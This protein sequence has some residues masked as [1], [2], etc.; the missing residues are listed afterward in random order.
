MDSHID[1]RIFSRICEKIPT[2]STTS[3]KRLIWGASISSSGSLFLPKSTR[4]FFR[5]E[6]QN[7]IFYCLYF[8]L[9]NGR[10][11]TSISRGKKY[12][13]SDA[14]TS[15]WE[16]SHVVVY[17]CPFDSLTR[18]E[19]NKLIGI[20]FS[21]W[22]TVTEPRVVH[23]DKT[24]SAVS[25]SDWFSCDWSRHGSTRAEACWLQWVR[26]YWRGAEGTIHKPSNDTLMHAEEIIC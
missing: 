18:R 6:S 19:L 3:C 12:S 15:A 9:W 8:H 17:F 5:K 20:Q 13:L 24:E 7:K 14:H 10:W 1:Y 22:L 16:S 2:K 4:C 26:E 11:K 25:T 21:L 23:L